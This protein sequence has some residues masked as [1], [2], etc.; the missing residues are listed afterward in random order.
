MVSAS[1]NY[2][3]MNR[4]FNNF[5]AGLALKA[6]P[7]NWYIISDNIPLVY[8]REINEN[9]IIPHKARAVNFRIGFNLVFACQKDKRKFGDLPLFF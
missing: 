1:L 9:I 2:T 6:G 7:F 5:G 3:I 4:T 8:A